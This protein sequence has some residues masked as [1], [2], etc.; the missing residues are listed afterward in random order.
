MAP[1]LLGRWAAALLLMGCLATATGWNLVEYH[2][3][4][5]KKFELAQQT[6]ALPMGCDL[7][8]KACE[9]AVRHNFYALLQALKQDPTYV[10]QQY[11]VF[12][13]DPRFFSGAYIDKPF[14]TLLMPCAIQPFSIPALTGMPLLSALHERG[15]DC[16]YNSYGY[17]YLPNHASASEA[18]LEDACALAHDRGFS[19]VAIIHRQDERFVAE[20]RNCAAD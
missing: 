14:D 19:H 3:A 17:Q 7:D 4:M 12:V 20:R 9:R 1:A 13:D 10:K 5:G 6:A 18:D 11:A 8:D 16:A 15:N 2:R